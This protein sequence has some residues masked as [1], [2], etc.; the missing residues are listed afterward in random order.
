M[1]SSFVAHPNPLTAIAAAALLFVVILGGPAPAQGPGP[2]PL[3]ALMHEVVPPDT[4]LPKP[5][6]PANPDLSARAPGPVTGQ[7]DTG[8]DSPVENAWDFAD[9]DSIPGFASVPFPL[10]RP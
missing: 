5:Y 3:D 6:R 8:V 10:A 9:P 7:A 2:S 1:T 4:G